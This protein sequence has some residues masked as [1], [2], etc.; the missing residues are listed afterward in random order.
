M[1]YKGKHHQRHSKQTKTVASV[2]L[3]LQELSL[4]EKME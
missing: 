3:L 4:Q 1:P 2:E